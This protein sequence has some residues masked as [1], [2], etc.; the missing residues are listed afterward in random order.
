MKARKD[1]CKLAWCPYK[2]VDFRFN[3]LYKAGHKVNAS[4]IDL[5]LEVDHRIQA[6]FEVKKRWQTG[7]KN[8]LIPLKQF[9]LTRKIANAFN[10]PLFFVIYDEFSKVFF[11]CETNPRKKEEPK[12]INGQWFIELDRNKFAVKDQEELE[13]F[14]L[15]RFG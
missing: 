1:E 5:V 7:D 15:Q 8:F 13:D 12:K 4:D 11:I 14:W 10:V 6:I 2:P 9:L 3:K